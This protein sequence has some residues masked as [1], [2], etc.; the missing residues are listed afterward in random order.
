M[1][2]EYEDQGLPVMMKKRSSNKKIA[3]KISVKKLSRGPTNL[4][5]RDIN[6]FGLRTSEGKQK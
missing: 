4:N 2:D 6:V 5:H 3:Q 1:P